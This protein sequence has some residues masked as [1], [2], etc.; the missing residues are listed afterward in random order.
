MRYE[1]Y[2]TKKGTFWKVTGYLGLDPLTGKQKNINKKGFSTK[3][4]AKV[5]VDTAIKQLETMDYNPMNNHLTYEQVYRE[6][7]EQYRHTVKESTLNT[8]RILFDVYILPVFG[9]LR[10][11]KI[12]PLYIQRV[13]NK[14]NNDY[15]ISRDIIARTLAIFTFAVKMDYLPKNPREKITLPKKLRSLDDDAKKEYY[16]RDELESILTTME[17]ESKPVWYTFFRLIAFS[18]MRKGEALALTWDDINFNDNTIS[19]NKTLAMGINNTQVIQTPKTPSSKRTITMDHKTMQVLKRWKHTQT[20]ERLKLGFPISSK[21]QCLF[22]KQAINFPINTNSPA[23]FYRDFCKRYGFDFIKIHGFRHTHASLL[24]ESGATV[25]AVQVRLGHA[26]ISTTMD[27]YT[28][29]TKA[30]NDKTAQS[31]AMYMDF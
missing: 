16:T 28:H 24:F 21:G 29:V 6:W 13:I 30:V 25:K 3:R 31:F 20:V 12:S 14:W 2:T 27:V 10:I 17:R 7:F 15:K 18:G 22:C 11:N 19:I 5:F 26:N 4:E 1:Q 23:M 8:V 9:S